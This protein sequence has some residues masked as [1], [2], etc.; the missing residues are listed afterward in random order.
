MTQL[1]EKQYQLMTGYIN[2]ESPELNIRGTIVDEHVFHGTIRV[3]DNTIDGEIDITDIEKQ[4]DI[5][6]RDYL[7]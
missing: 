5:N 7:K 2:Y 3:E 6:L 1:T 4:Y